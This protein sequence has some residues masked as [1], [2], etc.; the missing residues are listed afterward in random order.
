MPDKEMLKCVRTKKDVFETGRINYILRTYL[1][2]WRYEERLEEIIRYCKEAS[3]EHVLLFSD[4]Q[5]MVWNQLTLDEARREADTIHRAGLRLKNEGLSLGINV[6]YNMPV[7]HDDHRL[8]ND[9]DYWTVLQDGTCK[10]STPCLLDPKLEVYLHDLYTILAQSQPDYIFVDDDHRYVELGAQG[11]WGCFCDLHLSLFGER[12]GYRW[13]RSELS[14]ALNCDTHIRSEWIKFL[15]ERLVYLAEIMKKAVHGVDPD[16]DVGIMVPSVH[17]LPVIGHTITNI[18]NAL[19]GE[20]RPLVRPC[21]G[22]YQDHNHRYIIPGLFYMEYTGHLLGDEALYIPEIEMTPYTRFSKSMTVVHFQI[23]QGV[24]NGMS[25]PALSVCGYVGDSPGLEPAFMDMLRDERAFFEGVMSIAPKRGSRKGIQQIWRFEAP[26]L[27]RHAVKTPTELFWPAFVWNDVLGNMGFPCTY[28]ESPIRLLAGDSVRALDS[29]RIRE[30]LSGGVLLDAAAARALGE[31][32]YA[33]DTGCEV[34]GIL[35]GHGAEECT[36]QEFCVPYVNT[37]IPLSGFIGDSSVFR[38]KMLEGAC[39]LSRI[40]DHDR[41]ELA[42]GTVI[43]RNPLG[44]RVAVIPYELGVEAAPQH[45]ICYQRSAMLRKIFTWMNPSG[46]P[47]MIEQPSGFALQVWS[48]SERTLACITNTSYDYTDR[49]TLQL[50]IS[51]LSPNNAFYVA[52]NG[53]CVSLSDKVSVGGQGEL[54]ELEHEFMAFRPFVFYVNRHDKCGIRGGA[55]SW[56]E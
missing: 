37:Y 12:T 4:A 52:D 27:S 36:D 8:H 9:Y 42:P 22:P 44:G 17:C 24:L 18:V 3:I 15:G 46:I 50:A 33:D 14:D 43:F 2:Y 45:M 23:T 20:R 53:D 41:R 34:E 5:Q 40:T 11:T 49:V 32:G 10:F 31:M 51:G 26:C 6:T 7:S 19:K 38:L 47:L 29:N 55:V 39:S 1:P 28:D 16:I 35:H 56:K 48:D 30:I 25:N 21:I 13:K 54:W